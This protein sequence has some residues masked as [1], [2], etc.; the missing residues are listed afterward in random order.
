[1]FKNNVVNGDTYE[2]RYIVSW[3][4]AGGELRYLNDIDNFRKWLLSLGLKN[5][6]I[7][8]TVYLAT[9]GKF[10]LESSAKTFLENIK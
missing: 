4:K 7:Q 3:L 9:T 6:E 10:E 8:H 1:M 2:T 5:N